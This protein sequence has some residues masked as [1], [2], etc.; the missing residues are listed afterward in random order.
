MT[1]KVFVFLDWLIDFP[2]T[3]VWLLACL[4]KP[5]L[6]SKEKEG[7]RERGGKG[8]CDKWMWPLGTG[9]AT[10]LY[11]APG[12]HPTARATCSEN[13]ICPLSTLSYFYP[14]SKTIC[15]PVMYLLTVWNCAQDCTQ[16]CIRSSINYFPTFLLHP[17]DWFP[18]TADQKEPPILTKNWSWR[19]KLPF[20]GPFLNVGNKYFIY[21]WLWKLGTWHLCTESFFSG[22]SLVAP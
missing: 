7:V 20:F 13:L 11:W 9:P 3:L 15:Y 10:S 19:K 21:V 18:C 2:P 22:F 16:G 12:G 8:W 14:P 17:G 5:R 4:F 1:E 6:I